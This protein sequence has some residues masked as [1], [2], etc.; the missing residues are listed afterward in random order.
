[1]KRARLLRFNKPWGVLC[2]FTDAAGRPTLADLVPVRNVYPAGRL[3]ADSEGLLLLTNDG[4]LQQR[5]A[6]PRRKLV[7]TYWVQVEGEPPPDALERLRRGVALRDGPARAVAVKR[8]ATP[9]LWPRHPPIRFRRNLPATW[10]EVVLTEGRNRQVRRMTAAIGHPT[11]R[12]VRVAIGPWSLGDLKPGEWAEAELGTGFEGAEGGAARDSG[13]S[14]PKYTGGVPKKKRRRLAP[15]NPHAV[16][17]ASRHAGHRHL[18]SALRER[19]VRLGAKTK[20]S[21]RA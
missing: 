7:K 17:A 16:K 6:D 19:R 11:L 13:P 2:Q 12:L 14:A 15:L 3:D 18:Q 5:I 8:I 21:G 10:I 20:Q 4:F 9:A 1:M